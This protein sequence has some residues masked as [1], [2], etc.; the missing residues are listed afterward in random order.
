MDFGDRFGHKAYAQI[1]TPDGPTDSALFSNGGGYTTYNGGTF[2]TGAA[3]DAS[4]RYVFNPD[5]SVRHQNFNGPYDNTGR[6]SD[7]DR[8]DVNQVLQL[9][10]KYSRT[11]VSSVASFD[12]TPEHRLYA[13]GTYS[14]IDVTKY[15]QP[16]FGSGG[17]AY[18]ITR[19]NAFIDP[20]PGRGDG[21]Q[22]AQQHQGVAL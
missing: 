11:T 21:C 17:T 14:H 16:A 15:G 3:A 2:S 8:S 22:Q 20:N 5:G 10:P 9:Q 19:D 4:K 13:E 6:C 18:T 1:L 7:C 12:I